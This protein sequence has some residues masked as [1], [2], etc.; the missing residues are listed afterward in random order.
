MYLYRSTLCLLTVLFGLTGG[1]KIL[2][3]FPSCGYSQFILGERL[4]RELTARGHEVTVISLFEPKDP[5][6]Y[7]TI[8]LK[9]VLETFKQGILVINESSPK[10]YLHLCKVLILKSIHLYN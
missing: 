10:N 3:V 6:N 7:T 5:Q 2:S 8:H 9:D 1:A 4:I